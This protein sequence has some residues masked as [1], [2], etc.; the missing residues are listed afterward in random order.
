MS[1]L[2]SDPNAGKSGEQPV[3]VGSAARATSPFVIAAVLGLLGIGLFLYLNARRTAATDSLVTPAADQTMAAAPPPPLEIAPRPPVP[4]V[5]VPVVPPPTPAPA[6]L[7]APPPPDDTVQRLHAPTVVVDLQT[8][9]TAAIPAPASGPPATLAGQG[10]PSK[11]ATADKPDATAGAVAGAA[12]AAALGAAN[13]AAPAMAGGNGGL[14]NANEQFAAHA[15]D[16]MPE[17]AIATQMSNLGT[18]ITQ[19]A[20]IPAVLETAV[21]SDLPGF[22]RAI[23]SRD[24]LGFDG[25]NV[26]I[27]RG[28]RVIGQYRN[29]L[30]LGQERVFVIW[31]RVIRPDGVTVQIGSPGDDALGRGGLTG[32]VNTHFFARFGGSILLSVLNAGVAAVAGTPSTTISIGSPAAAAGA[33]ATASIPTDTNILPTISVKQGAP[34]DIFVARDLDFST[35]QPVK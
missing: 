28:S 10:G 1:N 12:G 25:K 9:R 33:A 24:V 22:T 18:T 4:P 27:P 34:I 35:V 5:A 26:L 16:A 31:T 2:G 7:V 11:L 15:S 19:G 17:P 13:A 6:V 23:V 14:L 29:A 32:D 8:G 20:T 30:S 21:S 3:T